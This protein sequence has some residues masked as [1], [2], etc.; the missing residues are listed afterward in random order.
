[1]TEVK[2]SI[3]AGWVVF[4]ILAA[5]LALNGGAAVRDCQSLR[6]VHEGEEAPNFSIPTITANGD[7]GPSFTLAESRGDIIVLDFWATW[8]GPCKASMPVLN[9][10]AKKYASQG[11]RVVSINTEGGGA[12]QAARKMANRLAPSLELASDTGIASSLYKV[13]TIPHMLIVDRAGTVRWVHRGMG[14]TAQLRRD[15]ERA[16]EALL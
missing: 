10:I 5:L 1:M 16:I 9:G 2:R 15:L 14:T 8:C 13:N 12:S 6:P 3:R 7:L 4:A 11:V